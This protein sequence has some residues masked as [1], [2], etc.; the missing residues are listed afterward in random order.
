MWS[1]PRRRSDASQ[2]AASRKVI[3]SDSAIDRPDRLL[4]A[5]RPVELRHAH[6]A[7]AAADTSRLSRPAVRWFIEPAD[8]RALPRGTA[9]KASSST[10]REPI[11]RCY[12]PA[13]VPVLGRLAGGL[14]VAFGLISLDVGRYVG[15]RRRRSRVGIVLGV[16]L[17]VCLGSHALRLPPRASGQTP[18]ASARAR[19]GVRVSTSSKSEPRCRRT[20][21]PS[22]A[23][24]A[25]TSSTWRSPSSFGSPPIG[26]P[27]AIG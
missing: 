23:A 12:R 9:T 27:R 1:T 3:P 25:A 10:R 4:V 13:S 20:R 26:S 21:R 18:S 2:P 6:A 24:V 22:A 15:G 8:R 14:V 19:G 11:A 16:V 7:E 5:G 17:H